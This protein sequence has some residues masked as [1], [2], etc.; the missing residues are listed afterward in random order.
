MPNYTGRYRIRWS[1]GRPS[2]VQ[3]TDGDLEFDDLTEADYRQGMYKPP[4]ETLPWL[5]KEAK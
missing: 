2:T 4:L 1:D 5:D 3:V